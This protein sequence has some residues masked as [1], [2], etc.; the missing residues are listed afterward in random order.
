MDPLRLSHRSNPT[1]GASERVR[2]RLADAA[3]GSDPPPRGIHHANPKPLKRKKLTA[4]DF[5]VF[6]EGVGLSA[7]EQQY[8]PTPIINDLCFQMDRWRQHRNPKFYD[9]PGAGRGDPL[10]LF[11]FAK[12]R[13]PRCDLL[14]SAIAVISARSVSSAVQVRQRT[15][16]S[17][18]SCKCHNSLPPRWPTGFP[19][20]KSIN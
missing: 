3:D 16:K 19:L 6:N 14:K 13:I 11:I 8:D 9:L 20:P 12:G 5:L 18:L 10:Y 1:I 2:S 4:Q 7:A 15:S 17:S